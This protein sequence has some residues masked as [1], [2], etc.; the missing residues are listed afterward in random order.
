MVAWRGG[1]A[2]S[3]FS[4]GDVLGPWLG[5][6]A[7][8]R[9]YR[10]SQYPALSTASQLC[11][12]RA[13]L[14]F[15][16][17]D[18]SLSV[19]LCHGLGLLPLASPSLPRFYFDP[20]PPTTRPRHPLTSRRPVAREQITVRG[21]DSPLPLSLGNRVAR[22]ARVALLARSGQLTRRSGHATLPPPCPPPRGHYLRPIR[23]SSGVLSP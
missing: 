8:A 3:P 16:A 5:L 20:S 18:W 13:P 10:N 9:D 23:A 21:V 19:S 22:V 11:V 6:G 14:A 4:R 15:R 1:I 17:P 12:G 7:G 2:G